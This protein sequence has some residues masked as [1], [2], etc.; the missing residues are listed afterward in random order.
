MLMLA[1]TASLQLA[2]TGHHAG[3]EVKNRRMVRAELLG[4]HT[5]QTICGSNVQIWKRGD[6]YLARGRYQ[7]RQFGKSLGAGAVE[8]ASNLRH[9]LVEIENGTFERPSESRQRPLK[10]GRAPRLSIRELCD[11]F[12]AEK[13]KLV[14][15]ETAANYRSRLVPLIEF[16][17][18][19]ESRQRWPLAMD[20]DR[21]FA[22]RFRTGLFSRTVTRNGHPTSHETRMSPRQ[23]YNILD[24]ARSLFNWA[25]RP[26]VNQLPSTYVN[27]FTKDIVSEKP[28]KD[29]LR[30]I[31]IPLERRIALV[32]IMDRWQLSHFALS[33]VLPLRPEDL[34]GLLVSEIDFQHCVLRF[35]TRLGGRDF[36]KGRQT[37]TSPFP[38]CL[39][40]LLRE[41][42]GDR[43]DGPMLRRRAVWDGRKSAKWEV[44]S[45]NDI[46]D[47]FDE[48]LLS[49]PRNEIQAPQDNKRLFRAVL[50]DLGGISEDGLTKEFRPLHKQIGLPDWVRFYDLRASCNT[51]MDRSH[52]S[53]LVQR[54]VTGHQTRDILDEYVSLEHASDQMAKYFDFTKPLLA[55]IEER[56]QELG[57]Q[58]KA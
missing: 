38:E 37:F 2:D 36:N 13:R 16:S 5:H 25:R 41:C 23:A 7:K 30:P 18:Q 22:I 35:G 56:A 19:P 55:A 40:P 21:E 15:K 6:G 28:R 3:D 50:R 46:L 4:S 14:G 34:T 1:R 29:P 33:M 31:P 53:H 26:E 20:A 12:L 9:L 27:P 42:V 49:A 54:Y 51:D 47:R 10:T 24:C 43:F 39:A 52:V 11:R 45:T 57:S 48:A 32:R 58:D 44:L 17:E 8:A